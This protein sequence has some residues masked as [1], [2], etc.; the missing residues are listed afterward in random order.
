MAEG[1]KI[2]G[3]LADIDQAVRGL[4]AMNV[5]GGGSR[6]TDS[7]SVDRKQ[8]EPGNNSQE[9]GDHVEIGKT[10]D[11]DG[12]PGSPKSSKDDEEKPKIIGIY[13]IPG[14]GKTFLMNKLK[15]TLDSAH[16][17]FFEG[18]KVI[19]GLVLGGLK[20]FKEMSDAE[21][22]KWRKA[23][24]KKIQNDCVQ[25]KKV[26]IVTGHFTFW[27][28]SQEGY[29]PVW[30]LA[31]QG[32]FTFIIYLKPP[33]A[34]I[35][36][37][38]RSDTTRQDRPQESEWHLKRWQNEEQ[39]SLRGLCLNN[40][41]LFSSAI[42]SNDTDGT[43]DLVRKIAS[44]VESYRVNSEKTNL[45]SMIRKLDDTILWLE[46][47]IEVDGQRIE[48]VVLL[49]A[50]RTITAEDTGDLFWSMVA[51]LENS[52]EKSMTLKKLFGGPRGY[53]YTSFRQA[54]LL[55]KDEKTF[56][57]MGKEIMA[58]A[59]LHDEILELLRKLAKQHHVVVLIVTS[60]P[61]MFW[62]P[63]IEDLR[64]KVNGR[65][66]LIGAGMGDN[67]VTGAVKGA[68]VKHLQ[69]LKLFVWA[70]GDSPLDMDM[71]LEANEAIV[72]SGEAHK[73]S[74]SMDVALEEAIDVRGLRAHQVILPGNGHLRLDSQ[75]LP[76]VWLD[77]E[78]FI[79]RISCRHTQEPQS[80]ITLALNRHAIRLLMTPMRD[81]ALS[82]PH[83]RMA[84]TYA[85]WYVAIELLSRAIG[86]EKY[87][88]DHVQGNKTEGFKLLFEE[89][90]LIVAMLRGG[91]PFA[92]GINS[93]YPRAMFLHAGSPKDVDVRHL[94]LPD[95]TTIKMV[96]LVDAVINTGRSV[97]AFVKR[98]RELRRDVRIMIVAGVIQSDTLAPDGALI[99]ILN[100]Y[101]NIGIV[102]LRQSDNKFSGTG[103][104]D[105]GNRLFNTTHLN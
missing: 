103:G 40:G 5:A 44:M 66:G 67:V 19:D 7:Q 69:D 74:L 86:L 46:S 32:A 78:D 61:Y 50:D 36:E 93:A 57:T 73:R 41:I 24:I 21:K 28:E 49:D 80:R 92:F 82:G 23:C 26:G 2:S 104:T 56:S 101:N 16:F 13:G 100:A 3:E 91:E 18:S 75:R 10:E 47:L 42:G 11:R 54:M 14:S 43:N 77:D 96:L 17:D 59:P 63:T 95:S 98:I 97:A 70:F 81:A 87:E 12:E 30:T 1:S 79:D 76:I 83:L 15:L 58:I 29:T 88:I 64:S 72:V 20:A 99:E 84:H 31:D 34:L 22:A 6:S 65:I 9:G 45:E 68:I 25:S 89:E 37:R 62:G 85:G 8:H 105:T 55:Y 27:G 38:R 4:Q 90:T 39:R 102:G 35:A 48:T 33:P 51:E 71:L 94:T 53:S 52:F 60:G